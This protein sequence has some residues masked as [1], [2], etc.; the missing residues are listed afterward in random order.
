MTEATEQQPPNGT[1]RTAE[2]MERLL[3]TREQVGVLLAVDEG[4]V[5]HLHRIGK[6][7][8]CK[9][10]KGNRWRPADVRAFV[11]G[12]QPDGSGG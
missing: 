8:A 10:G 4:A 3:L 2:L 1:T 6:L 9:V 11:E 7:V 5:D 12:L